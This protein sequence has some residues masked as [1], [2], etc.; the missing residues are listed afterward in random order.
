[1]IASYAASLGLLPTDPAFW[2]P[3]VLLV[4]TALMVLG[5]IVFDGFD[6]G[7]GLLLPFAPVT[8]RQALMTSLAP[9]RSVNETWVLLTF[10]LAIASFPFAFGTILNQLYLPILLCMLGVVTRSISFEFR[11]R[12]ASSTRSFWLVIF[13][14][15]ALF[16]ALGLGLILAAFATGYQQDAT[17]LGFIL[18]VALCVMAA[19]MLIGACWLLMRWEG[20]VHMLA[21]RWAS[22]AVRWVA[23]G[24]TAVSIMLAMANPAILY[25]W[26]HI[27]NLIPAGLLW[28]VML[29]CFV[30]LEIYFKR[31]R[32]NQAPSRQWL[33]F[34]LC[35]VLLALMVLGILYSLF[36]FMVLDE[37]TLW[38]ATPSVLSMRLIL[39]ALIIVMPVIV[40]RHLSNY[41]LLFSPAGARL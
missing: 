15:G 11:V 6:M 41:R 31:V 38:D 17:N 3:L 40:L 21:A 2:M 7:V 24:M 20:E 33:P 13:F 5:T 36:P 1:M 32:Q 23:A 14:I 8:Y 37:I 12:S 35:V 28:F 29:A 9:W 16:S 10:A 19:C 27:N 26:T 25:K 39:A 34:A 4:I 30:W 18:F 22:H